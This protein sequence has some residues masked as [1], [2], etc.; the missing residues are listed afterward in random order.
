[1]EKD[2]EGKLVEKF[3]YSMHEGDYTP[4]LS[5]D[6]KYRATLMYGVF[7]IHELNERTEKSAF[8]ILGLRVNPGDILVFSNPKRYV[9]HVNLQVAR[10]RT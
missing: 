5:L 10:R 3:V 8:D 6:K 4:Y 9:G 1:M 2:G 7:Q